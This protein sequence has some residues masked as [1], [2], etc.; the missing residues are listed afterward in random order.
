MS[1]AA[2]FAALAAALLAGCAHVEELPDG[3]K[4]I[5]GLVRMTVPSAIPDGKRGGE[6]LQVT[7]FGLTFL[8]A[9]TASRISLGYASDRITTL[10]NNAVVHFQE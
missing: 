6:T 8:T 7:S 3:S 10:R 9:P 2:P 5:T 4:R 1:R